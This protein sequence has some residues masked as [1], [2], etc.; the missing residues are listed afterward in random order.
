MSLG[1][2]LGHYHLDFETKSEAD[3]LKVGSDVYSQH[4]ST[5]PLCLAYAQA[6]GEIKLWTPDMPPPSDLLQHVAEGG[7]LVGHNIGGFE[8]LIWNNVMT[9]KYGW[10]ELK[11]EQCECTMAMAYS[12]SLP[13]SLDDAARAAGIEY[14]KDMKGHRI[15]LQLSQPR[16][17]QPITWYDK[18]EFVDKYQALYLYCIQDVEVERALYK[19]LLKLSVA[20]RKIWELDWYI[21]RRGVYIDL[22]AAKKT[23]A[24]VDQEKIRLND[25]IREMTAGAV[26]TCTATGQLTDWLKWQGIEVPSVAKADVVELLNRDNLPDTVRKVLLLRQEAAKTSNAKLESMIKGANAAGRISGLFQYHGAS[27]G[28]W[29]GRRVI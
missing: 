27:T 6:E 12:M 17:L 14:N 23:V 9:L 22:P 29:A 19:K 21:N 2:F 10:P 25:K 3:L 24:L 5:E 4:Y 11:I 16:S 28:R 26:A 8:I 1:D 13:G 18:T 20:E 15:M 7:N